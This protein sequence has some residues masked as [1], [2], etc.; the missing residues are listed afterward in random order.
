MRN[1]ETKE[2][3][4]QGNK[5]KQENKMNKGT[6]EHETQEQGKRETGKQGN[7]GNKAEQGNKGE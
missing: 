6:G 4:K 1:R 5:R 7:R 2:Q 3:G